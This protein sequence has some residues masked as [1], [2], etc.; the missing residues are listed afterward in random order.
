MLKVYFEIEQYIDVSDPELA[1]LIPNT[2]E[3]NGLILVL[4]SFKQLE[5]ATLALQK[6]D[7]NLHEAREIFNE[8]LLNFPSLSS[9]VSADSP[10]VHS[11]VFEKAVCKI[12]KGSESSMTQ[13]EKDIMKPFLKAN[14]RNE[15]NS[16]NNN[17][18][19]ISED[20]GLSVV[21]RA[22][23]RARTIASTSSYI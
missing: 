9:H 18:R 20:A 23:K 22:L 13:D 10:I 11:R 14:W 19:E 1:A 6:Q 5:E 8:L 15:V 17:D 4:E 21:Q 2:V 7:L 16:R 12:L 3:R